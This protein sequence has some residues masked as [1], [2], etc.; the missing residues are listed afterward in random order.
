MFATPGPHIHAGIRGGQSSQAGRREPRALLGRFAPMPRFHFNLFN[1]V[2]TFDGE[3]H[4]LPDLAAAK[5]EAINSAREIM[6]AHIATGRPVHLDDRIE[7]ADCTGK[8]LAVIPFR[9]L[10]TVTDRQAS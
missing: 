10:I 6:A 5:A 8:V 4:D 3:G 9:E 1:D 7:V 2:D